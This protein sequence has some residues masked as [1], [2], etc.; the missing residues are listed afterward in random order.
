MRTS[1]L[2]ASALLCLLTAC[3][4][5]SPASQATADAST[6]ASSTAPSTVS[7]APTLATPQAVPGLTMTV[8]TIRS[9][10]NAGLDVA[11]SLDINQDTTMKAETNT[12]GRESL[13][14]L[15]PIVVKASR[16]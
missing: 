16:S 15:A 7:T 12:G 11:P 14:V 13:P 8:G 6:P 2:G 4:S 1:L 3:G 10:D 5:T 9:V